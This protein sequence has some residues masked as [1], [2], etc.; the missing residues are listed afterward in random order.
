MA[1]KSLNI[2]PIEKSG[3]VPTVKPVAYY[4]A[5]RNQHWDKV[6]S[7]MLEVF[8]FFETNHFV[9]YGPDDLR[10]LDTLVSTF[11]ACIV[12]PKFKPHHRLQTALVACNHI[13]GNL[14]ATTGY[15]NTDG[16]L[17]HVLKQ[18]D[19]L[20]KVL[21]LFNQRSTVPIDRSAFFEVNPGLAS[22]WYTA[23]TL[24]TSN[25]SELQFK[26]LYD[27]MAAM[28]DRWEPPHPKVSCMYFTTTYLAGPLDRMVKGKMNLACKKRLTIN[29]KHTPVVRD[30]K[31]I[32]IA[33]AK[34]HRN[35]A[36]YKSAGTLVE[37][38]A[39][40]YDLSLVHL[41]ERVPDN[42][43]TKGFKQV[44]NAKF[45]NHTLKLP[46]ELM[47]NSFDA[48]YYPDIGM[49]DESLWMSNSRICPIQAMGYGHPATSG[50]NSEIDYFIGGDCEKDV[51]H[52]YGE[53]MVL[54][55]GLAQEPVWPMYE[56]KN[57]WKDEGPVKINLVWGPDKYNWKMLSVLAEVSK[58]ASE[59]EHE[60]HMFPSPGIN[61]YGGFV[62]FSNSVKELLPNS[63]IYADL[64]YFPYMEA[65][66]KGDF[67]VNSFPFGGYN[68]IVEAMYLGLPVVTLEGD[69]YYN[70]AASYLLRKIGMG[71]L[72]HTNVEEFI[73][74][75]VNMIVN[76]ESRLDY[77]R[78]LAEYPLKEVLF[79]DPSGPKNFLKAFDY[80]FE[81]HPMP[82]DDVPILIGAE[83]DE[84]D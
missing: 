80:I 49:N 19:N 84:A 72:S 2:M 1:K 38:L 42:L 16:V 8:T 79:D 26:N 44:I 5:M 56:R 18:R 12:D 20:H 31:Q 71:E 11:F 51:A 63:V 45:D 32:A 3:E 40:K 41:G 82:K 83:N 47:Q 77:R 33:S 15:K 57:N 73:K 81:H 55:P 60:W 6:A 64:E 29:C 67:A 10:R 76:K 58:R 68:T 7:G 4:A 53:K 25:P 39:E 34:W 61:R 70:R 65:S 74:C 22:L 30:R 48:I 28:D 17:H 50:D 59:V 23:Y 75:C 43:V 69:R 13:F 14:V 46:A 62:P 54:I 66:E 37:A 24:G 21:F 36:V 78:R 35:H 52:C 9:A 27:H